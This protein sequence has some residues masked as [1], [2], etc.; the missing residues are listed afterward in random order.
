MAGRPVIPDVDSAA[1][2]TST[3]HCLLSIRHEKM[4]IQL[5]G[6]LALVFSCKHF[7]CL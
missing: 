1:L 7:R 2:S 3:V 4:S 5:H 6:S